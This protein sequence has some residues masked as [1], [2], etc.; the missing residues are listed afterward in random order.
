[1]HDAATGDELEVQEQG[2]EAVVPQFLVF[3]D[4]GHGPGDAIPDVQRPGLARRQV[5]A[6]QD[7][8][9]QVVVA[10][11]RLGVGGSFQQIVVPVALVAVALQLGQQIFE[12]VAGGR[13]L[14]CSGLGLIRWHETPLGSDK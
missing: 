3:F 9:G 6:A 7:V 10:V 13:R 1:M 4:R 8:D 12:A 11:I 14:R 2:E 5:L